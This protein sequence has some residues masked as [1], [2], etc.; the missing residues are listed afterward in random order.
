M[1]KNPIPR[2]RLI[3]RRKVAES[4]GVNVR[5]L[6]GMEQ[7]GEFPPSI[8]I[9]ERIRAYD[10]QALDAWFAERSRQS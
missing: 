2:K 4:L 9:S 7:R 3:P 6:K 10:E 8:Y 5:T 1:I